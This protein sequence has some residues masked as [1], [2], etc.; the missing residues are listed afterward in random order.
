FT[1]V[2]RAFWKSQGRFATELI[3]FSVQGN[4]LHLIVESTDSEALARAMKG[5]AIRVAI[6][7]NKLRGNHG[8]VFGDRYHVHIL[9][10]PSEVN[11]AVHYVLKNHE[12][13]ARRALPPDDFSSERHPRIVRP[14]RTWLLQRHGVPPAARRARP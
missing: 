4:H 8:R 12:R 3:Q 14:P 10:T 5:L 9:R 2:A 11:R 13:H 7:I 6:A 1:E